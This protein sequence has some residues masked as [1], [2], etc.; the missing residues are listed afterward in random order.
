MWGRAPPPGCNRPGLLASWP[1]RVYRT[2][3][4]EGPQRAPLFPPSEP[5]KL[6]L[7]PLRSESD[8]ER[9]RGPACPLVKPRGSSSQTAGTGSS[10]ITGLLGT[11]SYFL[12]LEGPGQQPLPFLWGGCGSKDGGKR[13]LLGDPS[14][15]HRAGAPGQWLGKAMWSLSSF[16]GGSARKP[17]GLWVSQA[18]CS[19]NLSLP[20]LSSVPDRPDFQC[21]NPH[22]HTVLRNTIF[23]CVQERR[24]YFS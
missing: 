10:P 5:R 18:A 11:N 1:P 23:E 24:I 3:G 8:L 14:A 15:A 17:R 20:K 9:C 12:R 22:P 2:E 19:Q 6:A 4:A 13:A 21:T 16:R 7:A